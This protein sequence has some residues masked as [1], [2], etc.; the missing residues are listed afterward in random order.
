MNTNNINIVR[1]QEISPVC[2]RLAVLRCLQ[3]RICRRG[4][5]RTYMYTASQKNC[6]TIHS[7][8]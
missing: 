7:F 4:K 5:F 8:I 2:N 6:E 3:E 1:V